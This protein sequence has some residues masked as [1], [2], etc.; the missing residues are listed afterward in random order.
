MKNLLWVFS[1]ILIMVSTLSCVK[2]SQKKVQWQHP[3]DVN[4]DLEERTVS[5][6]IDVKRGLEKPK[7]VLI[8]PLSGQVLQLLLR[9]PNSIQKLL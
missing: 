5:V 8:D 6:T 9:Q 1:L 7:L 4:E 2:T 3:T